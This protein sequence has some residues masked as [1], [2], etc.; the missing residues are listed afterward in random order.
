[1]TGLFLDLHSYSQVV[2]WPWAYT[3]TPAHDAAALRT[4]GRRMAYFNGYKPEQWFD[5]YAADGTTG[6]SLYALLG[7]PSYT[8]EL[9]VAFFETCRYFETS[10]LAKNLATLRYAARNL[11]G[12]YLIRRVPTTTAVSLSASSVT[13]RDAGHG[14][15]DGRRQPL[16]PSNGTEAGAGDRR[17]AA[18][19]RFAT[20]AVGTALLRDARQRW[21]LR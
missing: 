5:M 15:G 14:D 2:L 6:D 10:T 12:P 3:S 17:R 7:V 19:R 9:G 18:Y 11:A 20:V 8:I 13:R 4:F 16:Q 21:R 1:M